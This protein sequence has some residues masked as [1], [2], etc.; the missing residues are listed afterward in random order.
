MRLLLSLYF[1][2][3]YKIINESKYSYYYILQIMLSLLININKATE[4]SRKNNYN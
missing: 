1:N 4:R 3:H 2:C